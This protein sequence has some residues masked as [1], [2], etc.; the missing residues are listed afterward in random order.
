MTVNHK[1][2]SKR[3]WIPVLEPEIPTVKIT[4]VE[5]EQEEII[6]QNYRRNGK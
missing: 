5:K 2:M 4:V 3:K 6:K 1:D